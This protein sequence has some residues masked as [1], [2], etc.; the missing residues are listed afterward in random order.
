MTALALRRRRLF[1]LADEHV[2]ESKDDVVDSDYMGSHWLATF[3]VQALL[4]RE[5]AAAEL[6]T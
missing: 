6:G 2:L 5:V 1:A 3:L 4:R